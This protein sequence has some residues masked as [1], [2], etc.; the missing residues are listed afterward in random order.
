MYLI[1]VCLLLAVL[2]IIL[3]SKPEPIQ[4]KGAKEF[5]RIMKEQV[6][7]WIIDIEYYFEKSSG[8]FSINLVGYSDENGDLGDGGVLIPDEK[9]AFD[10]SGSKGSKSI[11]LVGSVS[12]EYTGNRWEKTK[13]KTIKGQQEYLLDYSELLYGLSRQNI[14][15]LKEIP[16]IN[17][18]KIKIVYGNIKTKTFFYP[19]K[20]S[21]F[22]INNEK[23]RLQKDNANIRFDKAQ[24]RG[25]SYDLIFYEMNLS[26]EYVQ[27]MLR[28]ENNF[29]YEEVE[30]VDQESLDWLID[31]YLKN[32]NVD[33]VLSMEEIYEQLHSRAQIIEREYKYLPKELP[34][35]VRKLT[36]EITAH[37]DTDYD[38]LK[39]IE[40]FLQQYTY[41]LSPGKLPE[42]KD[43]VDYFLFEN[44]KGYCTA[45]ASS[46]AIMGRCIGI[47]TRYVEGYV[48]TFD[49]VSKNGMY[50]VQNRQAHAWAEAYIEGVGWI[51]FEGTP[52]FYS[53]RYQSWGEKSKKQESV[54]SD[55]NPYG[56]LQ[57]YDIP[58]ISGSDNPLLDETMEEDNHVIMGITITIV[59]IFILLFVVLI[60]KF[61]LRYQY[62]KMVRKADYNHKMY[63]LFLRILHLLKLE[64][65][66]LNQQET[67]QMLS[68]RVKDIFHYENIKFTDVANIYMRYRYGETDI[69]Q[70]ELQRVELFQQGLFDK[71][72][73]EE[74]K[75]RVWFEEFVFLTNKGNW[76]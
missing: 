20:T 31:N 38:K 62:R 32:D 37:Y 54:D 45:F 6:E 60:Y 26:E 12:N 73:Q 51:P 1:P 47:P 44:Q 57:D 30:K 29:S 14:E 68:D 15:L 3:P 75:I 27:E 34:D 69:T 63:L 42:G 10:I 25:S 65:Y 11:Y 19:L 59:A 24:G 52:D 35:R 28:E 17:Q 5:Y 41:T 66:T 7:D 18:R 56:H 39:A 49:K 23:E 33:I 58:A 64:G 76:G 43:F 70:K 74:S 61:L 2:S 71:R 9:I 72:K 36:E 4:W 40:I 13:Q 48:A 8:D 67:I 50:P 16:Y 21:Y 46:L 22:N 53:I 55:Y